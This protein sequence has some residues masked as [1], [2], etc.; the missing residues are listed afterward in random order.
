VSRSAAE[1]RPRTSRSIVLRIPSSQ[2]SNR[3]GLSSDSQP[4]G[5]KGAVAELVLFVVRE[6]YRVLMAFSGLLALG[7]G[8]GR[9]K[10]I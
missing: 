6:G 2:C 10:V 8:R 3:T 9:S 1:R 5:S 7:S 4:R